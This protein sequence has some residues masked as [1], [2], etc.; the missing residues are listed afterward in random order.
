MLEEIKP[1]EPPL[2]KSITQQHHF[3]HTLLPR[4][5]LGS[6]LIAKQR[7]GLHELVKK[8]VFT[9]CSTSSF[10][11]VCQK[12][13][14]ELAHH[15]RTQIFSINFEHVNMLVSEVNAECMDF[16]LKQFPETPSAYEDVS[17]HKTNERHLPT[18]KNIRKNQFDIPPRARL[19]T[20]GFLCGSRYTNMLAA[21][22]S[23]WM[24][25]AVHWNACR[26]A[27]TM[28]R[29][30]II[31]LETVVELKAS[32]AENSDL[33]VIMKELRDIGYCVDHM[34]L[35]ALDYGSQTRKECLAIFGYVTHNLPNVHRLGL[36]KRLVINMQIP[37]EFNT[38]KIEDFVTT[39]VDGRQ[40]VS[41]AP[42]AKMAKKDPDYQK[43][44]MEIFGELNI[45]WPPPDDVMVT[46]ELLKNLRGAHATRRCLESVYCCHMAFP[47]PPD[48]IHQFLDSNCSLR[49][50]VTGVSPWTSHLTMSGSAVP[51]MRFQY[52]GF[53]KVGSGCTSSTQFRISQIRGFEMMQFAGW[54]A[55]M[56]KADTDI[57]ND[58][59]LSRM[60]GS[61]WNAFAFAPLLGALISFLEF[62][63]T[64]HMDDSNEK[65]HQIISESEDD[66]ESASTD[67]GPMSF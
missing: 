32:D 42:S 59:A 52:I 35:E 63:C 27:I 5:G 2:R 61:M 1:H 9:T 53:G 43:E 25:T 48:V 22:P 50:L 30:D 29:P 19:L 55:S 67:S 4:Q 26:D 31:C 56:Y 6:D 21:S 23:S 16:L 36:V 51:V 20:G 47:M 8:G 40:M 65:E 13:Y 12:I 28:L 45:P 58:Q 38:N 10:T 66:F 14:E 39:G 60:A 17:G 41:M 7:K 18:K 44:H 54:D 46:G 37:C 34:V 57:P 64:D 11:D 3:A 62:P 33:N 15:W 49:M 24:Q